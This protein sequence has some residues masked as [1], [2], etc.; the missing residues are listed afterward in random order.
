MANAS[1]PQ[2]KTEHKYAESMKET[3]ALSHGCKKNSF[4]YGTAPLAE[5]DHKPSTAIAKIGLINISWR[6]EIVFSVTNV[7]FT[8]SVSL[9]E[10]CCLQANSQ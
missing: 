7:C 1:L 9:G 5:T 2:T 3:L 4:I 8:N 6:E 10:I